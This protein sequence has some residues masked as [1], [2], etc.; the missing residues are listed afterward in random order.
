MDPVVDRNGGVDVKE[1]GTEGANWTQPA[2]VRD[3]WWAP[4]I[5]EHDSEPS[6][7]INGGIS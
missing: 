1:I 6:G 2:Q 7:S 3:H 4:V 5:C